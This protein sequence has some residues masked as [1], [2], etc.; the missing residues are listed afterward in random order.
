MY[1]KDMVAAYYHVYL[2]Q[3]FTTFLAGIKDEGVNTLFSRLFSLYL[4][5]RLIKDG[6]YFREH[7]DQQKFDEIKESI[8]DSLAELRPDTIGMTDI[9]PFANRMLGPFGNEDL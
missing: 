9:L 7:L 8:L 1:V 2:I 5:N 3:T 4:R 6:G